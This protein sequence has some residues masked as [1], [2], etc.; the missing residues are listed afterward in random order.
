ERQHQSMLELT[1]E[2]PD[3]MNAIATGKWSNAGGQMVSNALEEH[4]GLVTKIDSLSSLISNLDDQLNPITRGRGD[5]L[6]ED[7]RT[8]L[9]AQMDAARSARMEASMRLKEVE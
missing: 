8:A 1:G 6:P 7:E 3:L 2:N 9:W 5:I 4:G